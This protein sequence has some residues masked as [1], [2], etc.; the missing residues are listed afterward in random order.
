MWHLGTKYWIK[1]FPYHVHARFLTS[2]YK[3][4]WG[5]GGLESQKV[6]AKSWH[7]LSSSRAF[8]FLLF[9]L[10]LVVATPIWQ[11]P[12]SNMNVGWFCFF[13]PHTRFFNLGLI[14]FGWVHK[15]P[16]FCTM[17]RSGALKK[18]R[19][20]RNDTRNEI[21]FPISRHVNACISRGRKGFQNF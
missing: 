18:Q 6:P 1:C 15:K 19:E 14:H 17:S 9:F 3:N 8:C 11:N 4:F 16:L 12:P 2:W 5:R 7:M 20:R 10:V 13:S 21:L